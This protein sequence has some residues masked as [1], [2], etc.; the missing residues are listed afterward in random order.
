MPQSKSNHIV[1][2]DY[3]GKVAN[4]GRT[5]L[6]PALLEAQK[7]FNHIPKEIAAE[8]GVVLNVPLADMTGLIEFYSMLYTKPTGDTVIRVCTSPTC[9]VQG[10]RLLHQ[11]LLSD[12]GIENATATSDGQYFVE[13]VECL[14]LCDQAPAALVNEAPVG[15]AT[16]ESLFEAYNGYQTPVYGEE[17]LITHRIGMIDPISLKDYLADD[18]FVGLC[19]A[20]DIESDY[21]CDF[22]ENSG[23]LGRGGAAFVTRRKWEGAASADGE[24]KYVVC[25]ADES[26]PGTFKDRVLLENDPYAILEGMLIAGFAIGAGKGYIYI[27]GEYPQAQKVFAQVIQSAREHGYLGENIL[28]FGIFL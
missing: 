2:L 9:S 16:P 4:R 10:G 28:G 20:L 3:L 5:M 15:H 19:N 11:A 25:N 27:R 24:P 23:L 7:R 6:L 1:Y 14:G 8:I 18:G 21:I 12:F 26:E 17:K 13:K 22:M